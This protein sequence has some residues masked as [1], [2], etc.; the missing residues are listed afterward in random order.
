MSHFSLSD[1]Y[2]VRIKNRMFCYIKELGIII[3]TYKGL[4]DMDFDL[5]NDCYVHNIDKKDIESAYR[6]KETY[7][8][9]KGHE[10]RF[11]NY[12]EET[13]EFFV[14]FDNDLAG[15]ALGIKPRMETHEKPYAVYEAIIPDKD[16]PEIYEIRE[17]VTGFIFESPRIVFH[18]KN[19]KW[20]PYHELGAP[21]KDEEWL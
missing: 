17:P 6:V 11:V 12:N 8:V 13:G 14:V 2:I 16:I 1:T 10:A 5:K 3:G 9:Y 20:L 19:G 15:D 21:L 18:K 7:V 4:S